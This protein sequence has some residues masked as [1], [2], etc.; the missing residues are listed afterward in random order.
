MSGRA[1]GGARF[2]VVTVVTGSVSRASD[3]QPISLRVAFR[4]EATCR[5]FL[6]LPVP[7]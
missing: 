3:E 6:F 1:S 4:W 2:S 5:V 7:P